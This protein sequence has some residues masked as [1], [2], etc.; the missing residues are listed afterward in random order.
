MSKKI[1]Q[2]NVE[3]I[4]NKLPINY[5]P[6]DYKNM[7]QIVQFHCTKCD[8]IIE[9]KISDL[10]R[11]RTK[12]MACSGNVK[13]SQ[14]DIECKLKEYIQF[15]PFTYTGMHQ[16]I[17]YVCPSCGK[18]KTAQIT[19]I[20]NG[21]ILCKT[22]SGKEKKTQE[23]A[24]KELT[25]KGIYFHPFTYK[26]N[27]TIIKYRCTQCNSIKQN[28]FIEIITGHTLCQ[29]C[30]ENKIAQNQNLSQ[31]EIERRLVDL[32]IEYKPFTYTRRRD[33]QIEIKCKQCGE[34]FET[35]VNNILD[36]RGSKICRRCQQSTST[37][38]NELKD[39]ILS[40][41][42][43]IEE[44]IKIGGKE[45]D[46]FI[47]SLNMAFE[48]NGSFW[49]NDI[50][51]P[52]QYHYN[53]ITTCQEN[54]VRLIIIWDYEWINNK[55]EI[56]SYIKAQLGFCENR[57]FARNCVVREISKKDADTLLYYH[58]QKTTT[59]TK[60]YGL[61][62]NEEL[63]LAMLFGKLSKN[64]F[65]KKPIAEWEIRREICKEGYSIVGGKSKVF[66][67]FLTDVNPV[68]VVSYVDRS[69]FSG[70]SYRIMG[71][72]LDHINQARYDWVYK[73]N[74]TFKKRQPN[75]YKEMKPLYDE[76]KV[77]KVYDGGRY[78]FLWK[79]GE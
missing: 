44:N 9:R 67:R 61:F 22:C 73:N 49:H 64:I 25:D 48:Y 13:Y 68:S 50:N 57:I 14:N 21:H 53:K 15:R 23:Q 10:L 6:F 75:I 28:K 17:T 7:R 71:F 78:C 39:F 47:P 18:E 29:K 19:H 60:Y 34:Y 30:G 45:V 62:Y 26:N 11:G 52:P 41:G 46:I 42:V 33:C 43:H 32:S 55:N 4:L 54:N 56:K 40:L 63:V 74:F 16:K 24:E 27:E 66:K 35:V 51:K 76:G 77:F 79:R 31:S 5:I 3:E 37:Q 58:Q 72:Q 20:L 1:T 38:E 69:K 65:T 12:C 70:N 8:K 59:T 36:K 2:E